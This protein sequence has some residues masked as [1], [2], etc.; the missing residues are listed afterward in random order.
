MSEFPVFDFST[1]QILCSRLGRQQQLLKQRQLGSQRYNDMYESV[2]RTQA[3]KKKHLIM[4]FKALA[5][6]C[7]YHQI[8]PSLPALYAENEMRDQRLYNI[9]KNHWITFQYQYKRR[10]AV[11]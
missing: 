1:Y 8:P 5:E 11:V 7:V 10:K 6:Y 2:K 4:F 3:M 9:V